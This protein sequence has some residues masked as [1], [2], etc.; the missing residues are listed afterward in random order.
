MNYSPKVKA[1]MQ[2]KN[3]P[4]S[5]KVHIGAQGSSSIGGNINVVTQN[6]IQNIS[7]QIPPYQVAAINGQN[8]N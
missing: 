5:A 4:N 1:Q 3:I 7:N 2:N 6:Y 8:G